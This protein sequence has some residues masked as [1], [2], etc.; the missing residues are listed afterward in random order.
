[1]KFLQ[2][3][4]VKNDVLEAV[5][6]A[7]RPF[8]DARPRLVLF[9]CDSERLEAFSAAISE[10]FPGTAAA[11]AATYASFSPQGVCRKGLNAA[12]LCGDVRVSAGLIGE[13]DKN[14][15]KYMGAVA[16][17][18]RK[19]GAD[20]DAGNTICFLLNP[21]GTN[22]EELV[23]D[24]LA[25]ALE[26]SGIRVMG[27]AASSDEMLSGSVSLN[28]SVYDDHSVFV[29]I[30]PEKGRV[31]IALENIFQPLGGSF[32]VTKADVESRTI[33]ELDGH[34]AAD[35]L[36]C[37][38]DVPFADLSKALAVH[39]LGRVPDG[40]L[41]IN[42]VRCVNPDRSVS[43][44]CRVFNHTPVA[45]LELRDMSQALGET[46][47]SVRAALPETVFSVMVNCFRRTDLFLGKGV[48]SEF[49]DTLAGALGSFIGISSFGE[50]LGSYQLSMSM[51]IATFSD[52]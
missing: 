19:M 5:R 45:L 48:M 52:R 10:F 30:R 51:L 32:M 7:C 15:M 33:Y 4:S 14:P 8:A 37:A 2:G 13:I 27:G 39:P 35:V 3:S 41:F 1:M 20:A 36:C 18:V 25:D 47:A 12:A 23:L 29:F 22:C 16:D 9:F 17:A 42:E 43:T 46:L 11:G 44:Y 24:T 50:Q 31:H 34:P 28:G 21:A 26:D 40:E 49:T 38:L 6:E